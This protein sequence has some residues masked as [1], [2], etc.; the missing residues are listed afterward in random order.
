MN[1][2]SSNRG[3]SPMGAVFSSPVVPDELAGIVRANQLASVA[4][5]VPAIMMAQLIS[6]AVL[7]I[8]FWSSGADQLLGPVSYTHLTLPTTPYV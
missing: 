8:A 6:G 5:L 7:L 2:G 4:T 3:I 1:T